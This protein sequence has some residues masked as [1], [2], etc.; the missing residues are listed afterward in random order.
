[1]IA[2]SQMDWKSHTSSTKGMADELADNR[3][4]GGYLEKKDFL[5]RVD[6]RRTGAF[7]SNKKGGRR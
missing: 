6:D 7:E 4:A 1:M 2:Q 5:E 3:R